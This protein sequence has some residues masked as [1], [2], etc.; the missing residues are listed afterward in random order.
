MLCAHIQRHN[1]SIKTKW[2]EA[3]RANEIESTRD[4]NGQPTRMQH[5]IAVQR[6][7]INYRHTF[8]AESAL[9]DA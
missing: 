1:N 2:R 5:G 6:R 8:A 9:D 3:M 4:V 7:Q